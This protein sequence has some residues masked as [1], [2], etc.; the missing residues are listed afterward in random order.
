[1]Q[2]ETTDEF[3]GSERHGL[4]RG[5]VFIVFPSKRDMVAVEAHQPVVGDGHAM[6]VA[7]Q[8]VEYVPGVAEG[9]L[10]IDHPLGLCRGCEKGGERLGVGKRSEEHT[11]ELQS[12][13]HLVCRLLL[14]KKKTKQHTCATPRT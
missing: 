10:R 8:I 6:G 14:E 3:I 1:M 2:Q 5:A 7:A 13:D 12:P 4:V 11:S 9:R